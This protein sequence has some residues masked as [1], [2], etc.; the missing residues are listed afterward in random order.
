MMCPTPLDIVVGPGTIGKYDVF[1]PS[2]TI[3]FSSRIR[4]S[5][6]GQ[7]SP[8]SQDVVLID[9]VMFKLLH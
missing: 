6:V 4:V 7:M 2:Q 1:F 3:L 9:S 5:K 8:Q